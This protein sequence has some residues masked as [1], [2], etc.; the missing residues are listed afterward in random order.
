[1]FLKFIFALTLCCCSFNSQEQGALSVTLA[2][3]TPTEPKIYYGGRSAD[4]I[5]LPVVQIRPTKS[6]LCTGVVIGKN[7]IV[8]AYHCVA[9]V[10]EPNV[11]CNKDFIDSLGDDFNPYEIYIYGGDEPNIGGSPLAVGVKT[12]H[13]QTKK[14]CN[15]DIAFIIVDREIGINPATIRLD[16]YIEPGETFKVAGY[17][18][19]NVNILGYN[20]KNYSVKLEMN[21]VPY[22]FYN[23]FEFYLSGGS[24]SQD[25]MRGGACNGDSGG[26]AFSEKTR[27]LVGILSRG[28]AC[29]SNDIRIYSFIGS[30]KDVLEAAVSESNTILE[31]QKSQAKQ[32]YTVESM[33]CSTSMVRR[34]PRHTLYEIYGCNFQII[35]CFFILLVIYYLLRKY[36]VL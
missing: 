8:T 19:N 10:K 23:G 32:D 18:L 31:I 1:M 30:H 5:L 25:V 6:S 16:S 17:G 2:N 34:G 33:T 28:G 29:E 14:L 9:E 12:L 7:L 26:P 36:D 4:P 21:Q 15:N 27:S 13:P 35:T 20:G 11:S 3:E 22:K 24:L